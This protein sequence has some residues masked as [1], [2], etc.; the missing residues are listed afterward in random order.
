M[1][2]PINFAE[3][4]KDLTHLEFIYESTLSKGAKKPK[5]TQADIIADRI[6]KGPPKGQQ[7][8]SGGIK[9]DIFS[10]TDIE[11]LTLNQQKA[12]VGGEDRKHDQTP[13]V[14]LPEMDAIIYVVAD[15][16]MCMMDR[17]KVGIHSGSYLDLCRRYNTGMADIQLCFAARSTLRI[18]KEIHKSLKEFRLPL[19]HIGGRSEVV[20]IP[21][22]ELI[23]RLRNFVESRHV[24]YMTDIRASD[25][26]KVIT[27]DGA[28]DRVRKWVSEYGIRKMLESPEV[29]ADTE[30]VHL[31]HRFDLWVRTSGVFLGIVE[32]VKQMYDER[33]ELIHVPTDTRKYF[34]VRY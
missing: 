18:E 22:S 6:S 13:T 12:R 17:Y 5:K 34:R 32:F 2:P 4:I 1:D 16:S 15:A 27:G 24:R 19:G 21:L 8:G 7:Y 29:K 20:V 10:L 30:L 3:L 11:K 28:H 33:C 25:N 23:R 14:V 26:R 31:Y 9:L